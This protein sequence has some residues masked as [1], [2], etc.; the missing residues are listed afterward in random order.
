MTPKR[1]LAFLCFVSFAVAMTQQSHAFTFN[2][3][4]EAA[5]LDP[6]WTIVGVNGSTV[7]F[8][9]TAHIHGGSQSVQLNTFNTGQQK[10]IQLNHNF[11]APLYGLFTT[12]VYDSGAGQAS[13][14]YLEAYVNSAGGA[15]TVK[16]F[17]QDFDLG[18]SNGGHY[19]YQTDA[20]GVVD[21]GIARTANWHQFSID[22][23]STG[24]ILKVDGTTV[25]SGP[26][27]TFSVLTINEHAPDFRSGQ[28]AWVDDVSINV[29]AAPEPTSA[30]LLSLGATLIVARRRRTLQ[31]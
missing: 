7:S 1:N 25:Y 18:P 15:Q 13:G 14:N 8:P 6:F 31:R 16:L 20:T 4:F 5:S 28:T 10:E 3:G 23:E 30:T 11:G 17:T 21:T 29:S 24:T 2:D 12:W 9:S 19:Y 26:A 27:G 22:L